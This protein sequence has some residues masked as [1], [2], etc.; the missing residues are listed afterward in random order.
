MVLFSC[1]KQLFYKGLYLRCGKKCNARDSLKTRIIISWCCFWFEN[2]YWNEGA[3]WGGVREKEEETWEGAHPSYFISCGQWK[4]VCFYLCGRKTT[5]LLITVPPSFTPALTNNGH[6]YLTHWRGSSMHELRGFF[7]EVL[8]PKLKVRFLLCFVFL[9]H[10]SCLDRYFR[11]S[12]SAVF[13]SYPVF[14]KNSLCT[15][16]WSC[17]SSNWVCQR[18]LASNYFILVVIFF[19][20]HYSEYS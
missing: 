11:S 10:D 14:D 7:G 6:N 12:T 3:E 18:N 20:F 15:I 9:L 5:S 8:Y 13:L 17:V 19:L 2:V 1:F 4:C 16:L